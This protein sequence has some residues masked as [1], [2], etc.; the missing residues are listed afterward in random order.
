MTRRP[1][2]RRALEKTG[3]FAELAV[4]LVLIWAIVTIPTALWMFDHD[5]RTVVIG[6]HTTTVSPTFDAHAT[7]DFGPLLPRMR[8]P[9][10]APFGLGVAIDVGDT[11]VNDVNELIARDA[12]IASQPEGEIGRVRS[13]VTGMA[14]DSGL[15]AAGVGL[16]ATL[17]IAVAWHV[18]GRERRT[19]VWHRLRN[20]RLVSR[21]EKSIGIA[22][23]GVFALAVVLITVP[24]GP[25][26]EVAAESGWRPLPEVIPG[27][28]D[29]D[30]F[31]S[32]ELSTGSAT[33]G[34][35]ALIESA[36]DTY[37]TSQKF[38]GEMRDRVP[39][40][41][42]DIRK[43]E[44][45]QT[46]AVLISDR[47]DNIGMDP[48]V[49]AVAREA[50]ADLILDAG[51]DTSTGGSW[52]A[53]SINSMERAFE[54]FE[55][56]GVAGNHDKGGFVRKALA[57]AGFEVLDGEPVDVE[58]IRFLGASDPRSSGLTAGY[59]EDSGSIEEQGERLTKIACEDENVS[60]VIVHSPTTGDPI[61]KSG[62]VDL[63]VSGHLHR[64]VG[65]DTINGEEGVTTS[66]TNGTTGGAAYAF[67]LGS[68]LRRPAEATL[69]TYE[70]GHPI[71]LQPVHF[72]T[73]G[74]ISVAD[75]QEIVTDET[76]ENDAPQGGNDG[77]PQGG[78]NGA[79][80]DNGAPQGGNDGN[81]QGGNDGNGDAGGQ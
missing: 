20:V 8:L 75:Y 26:P 25:E 45:D 2:R 34:G 54:D 55:K 71:G 37:Q 31:E 10:D 17:M 40:I 70:D 39:K 60:T 62:C 28:D 76:V 58:G 21:K 78:D 3:R 12:V 27:L 46:V 5:E 80:G 30:E 74:Q 43:P 24:T 13:H 1:F 77:A 73:S 11:D 79:R 38:Y 52:E 65:P 29:A 23:V 69:I 68:K 42:D 53:F 81:P 32:I 7:L 44:E 36:L 63:V 51:D 22:S 48:V 35:V 64:Q 66:Y 4:P 9:A 57:D 59:A 14:I 19:V 18:T 61:A 50:E 15:R 56:V 16:V 67:A 49:A 72:E 33:R 47:H 6:A 41:A